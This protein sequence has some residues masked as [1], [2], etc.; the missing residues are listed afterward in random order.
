MKNNLQVITSLL[1]LEARRSAQPDT[2]SVLVEMQGRIMAM[3]LLHESL[4]TSGRFAAVDLGAYLA[5]L[6]TQLFRVLVAESDAVQLHLDLA[7]VHVE[8]DQAMPCGLLVNELVSNCV[9]HGFPVGRKVRSP[10][11]AALVDGGRQVRLRVSDTGVGLPEDFD[12][13]RA[14]SLGLQLVSDLAGQLGGALDIGPGPAAVFTVT[15]P[16]AEP[17]VRVRPA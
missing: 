11:R 10:G 17:K 6:T 12:A 14:S 15:F 7:S 9:K 5:Q 1:R 4:Y 16:V 8:M 13:K 2:Q 3:A